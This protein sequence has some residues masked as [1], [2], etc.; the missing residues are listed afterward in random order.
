MF[1]RVSPCMAL[2]TDVISVGLLCGADP[3]GAFV[4]VLLVTVMFAPHSPTSLRSVGELFGKSF[5]A[6]LKG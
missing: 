6:M 2:C 1:I 5:W 4:T 3:M